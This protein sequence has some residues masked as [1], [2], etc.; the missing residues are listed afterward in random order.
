MIREA[1]GTPSEVRMEE[2]AIRYLVEDVDAAVAFYR[3]RLG[4]ELFQPVGARAR[5]LDPR[6]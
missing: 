4:F 2:V 3:D 1:G 5:V 6:A